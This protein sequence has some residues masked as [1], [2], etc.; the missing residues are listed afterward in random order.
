MEVNYQR[1]SDFIWKELKDEVVLL[2]PKTGDYFG[3]N[4]VGASFWKRLDGE[5]PLQAIVVGLLDE[6]DV[7]RVT[8]E[9]DLSDLIVKLTEKGLVL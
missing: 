5:T 8:L 7:D 9:N 4:A 1:N 2:N 6:F 3:L